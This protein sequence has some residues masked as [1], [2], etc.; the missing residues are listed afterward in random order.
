MRGTDSRML[1]MAQKR[2]GASFLIKTRPR[3]SLTGIS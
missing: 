3:R 1:G 2:A